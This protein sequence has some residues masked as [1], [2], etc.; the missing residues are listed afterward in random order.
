MPI[1]HCF[2]ERQAKAQELPRVGSFS[3]P[4]VLELE[5]VLGPILPLPLKRKE[6][7]LGNPRTVAQQATCHF[8]MLNLN[9]CT[10]LI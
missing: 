9:P 10:T 4:I 6:D 2:S 1:L 8:H 3:P 7:H 5:L